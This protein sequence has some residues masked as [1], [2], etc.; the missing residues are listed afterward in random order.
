LLQKK[1]GH[2]DQRGSPLAR[3]DA[4]GP[5]QLAKRRLEHGLVESV[6][7]F[8]ATNRPADHVATPEPP[9]SRPYD[10]RL[11]ST[12]FFP[13]TALSSDGQPLSPEQT[14]KLLDVAVTTST[15]W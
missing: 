10:A 5:V 12:P 3:S 7:M 9:D 14:A 13:I 4:A 11:A 2:A 6:S 1:S 15:K 8:V